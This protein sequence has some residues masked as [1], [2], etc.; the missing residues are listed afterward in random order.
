M[1]KVVVLIKNLFYNKCDFFGKSILKCICRENM[2]GE[3]I[4]EF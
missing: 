4:H 1:Q 3:N 2:A